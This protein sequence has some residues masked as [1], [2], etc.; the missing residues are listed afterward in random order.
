MKKLRLQNISY[1]ELLMSFKEW[2]DI[3]GYN[4]RTVYYMPIF[5]QEFF[6][7]LECQN[8]TSLEYLTID[9][10]KSYYT[11]LQE[12]DNQR[13]GGGLSKASLN[14]H[15]YALRTFRVYLKKH[16]AKTFKIHLRVEKRDSVIAD[17]VT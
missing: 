16:G 12:R 13:Q 3:L 11:Y 5:I 15:Q 10:V 2:L 7:W 9:I 4:E 8:I 14:K 17:I 1:K 6:H